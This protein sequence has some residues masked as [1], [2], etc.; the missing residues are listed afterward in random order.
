[1]RWT[2]PDG[3][4]FDPWMRTHWR[5]GAEVVR[6]VP[7]T[8]VIAGRV[9]DWEAWTDMVFPDSGPYVVPG[10]LQP[11]IVDRERDEGRD[12]DPSVWMVHR[13]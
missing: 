5:L 1:V 4:P 3:G 12:E 11:V 2:R 10:A 9:A 6:V 13:L 7:R 8:I